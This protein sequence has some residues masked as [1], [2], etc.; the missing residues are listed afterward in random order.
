VPSDRVTLT[1]TEVQ[2]AV[3]A[4]VGVE[5]GMVVLTEDQPPGRMLRI[6][7]AQPE[8]RAIMSAWQGAVSGRPSTWDL[9]QSSI[10][11]LGGRVYAVVITAVEEQRH[12]FAMLELWQGDERRTLAC[13]PSDGIALALRA[14][15][16]LL[17]EESVMEAAGVLADGSRP[18]PKRA[19]EPPPTR[20]GAAVTAAQAMGV[21]K[22]TAA[23][24]APAS[25]EAAAPESD[26]SPVAPSSREVDAAPPVD[27]SPQ[28]RPAG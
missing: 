15:S 9:L 23:V 14:Y 4:S 5:A 24:T 6:I 27:A 25:H 13:R 12:Y 26:A 11:L 22:S 8:A 2:L 19:P 28:D 7:I 1:V 21:P 3:P 17:A 18:P 10:A 20:T 16:Q